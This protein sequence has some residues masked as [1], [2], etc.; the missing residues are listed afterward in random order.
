[1]PRT[2]TGRKHMSRDTGTALLDGYDADAV[3]RALSDELR[4]TH[5]LFFHQRK[6]VLASVTAHSVETDANGVPVVGPGRPLTPE[7]EQALLDLMLGREQAE[8]VEILPPTVLYRDR[9]A[10]IWWLPPMIRPM[11]LRTHDDG[12]QTIV[13]HW[14]NLV[15]LVRN[16]TLHLVAV[17][18]SERPGASTELFHAPLPNVFASTQVCT[19]SARLPLA[20]RI[21][22]LPGWESVVFDSAFTHVNHDATLRAPERKQRKRAGPRAA[23]GNAQNARADASYWAARAGQVEPFPNASLNPLGI[24][25]AEWLPALGEAPARRN[26]R[27]GH[28]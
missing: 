23:A 9:N 27:R 21:S 11:H 28:H 5:G 26:H 8:P 4:T 15:A 10:T 14:P 17:E 1:M 3:N 20:M 16:R 7:D 12:A 18:G 19:G 25:L 22:D 2:N 24:T 13:T 6:Q